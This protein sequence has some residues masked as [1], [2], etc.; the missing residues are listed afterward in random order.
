MYRRAGLPRHEGAARGEARCPEQ[1]QG[2][3][4]Y[5]RRGGQEVGRWLSRR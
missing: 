3:E 1:I 2:D 4:R 5:R